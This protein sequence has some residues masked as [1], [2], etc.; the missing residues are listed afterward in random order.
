M[1]QGGSYAEPMPQDNV[2]EAM[3]ATPRLELH[4]INVDDLMSLSDTPDD[5]S[6]YEGEPYTNPHRI[7]MDES[8]PLRWRVPQVKSDPSVNKWFVRWMVEKETREIVG[9]SSFHGPPDEQGMMEI[10]LGVHTDFQRRGYA[11]EALTGMWSWVV[12]QPGVELLR[13]TV[14]PNNEASV[15]VIKKF[16]F[17]RV[18]QQIDPEDGPE[19][20]YEMSANEFRRRFN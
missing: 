16:G 6:I 14:D 7:L 2:S 17:E 9:S 4:H 5:V 18:G 3:I 12:D 20:I 11:T 8:G 1:C 15:A 10:G 13:Y 19:D